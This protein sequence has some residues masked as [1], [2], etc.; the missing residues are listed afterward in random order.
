MAWRAAAAA[1]SASAAAFS[2]ISSVRAERGRGGRGGPPS[3][4]SSSGPPNALPMLPSALVNSLG[5]TKILLAGP[6][7]SWGSIC[8][9][10]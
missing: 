8:R 2:S 3:G 4:P 10:W 1:A 7:A 6:W 9:Y 5:I